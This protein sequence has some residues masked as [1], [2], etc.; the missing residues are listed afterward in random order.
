[1]LWRAARGDTWDVPEKKA[2]AEPGAPTTFAYI[3]AAS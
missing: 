2:M 3:A 1:M